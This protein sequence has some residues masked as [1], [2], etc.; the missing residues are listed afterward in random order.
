MYKKFITDRFK[1]FALN[2]VCD[3]EIGE[4]KLEYQGQIFETYKRDW[5][6]YVEYNVQDV[7]L[8]KK[9]D[10]KRK[11]FDIVIPYCTECLITLDKCQSMIA[12]VEGYILKFMHK[13]N[14]RMNDIDRGNK[15][16]WWHE[17]G[18]YKVLDKDG[19]ITYQNCDYERGLLDFEDFA[20]K[21]GYCYAYHQTLPICNV[22]DMHNN[23]LL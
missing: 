21:A 18:K 17:T 10:D 8:I 6:R 12:A 9:L 16:D 15:R 7:L 23:N 14:I 22:R 5:N 1:S 19:N 11:V 4:G 2:Y 13:K 20:V 3:Q